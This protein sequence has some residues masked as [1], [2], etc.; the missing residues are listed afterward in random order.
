[1]RRDGMKV[2]A[3]LRALML[4]AAAAVVMTSAAWAAVH[5]RIDGARLEAMMSD[6]KPIVIVDVRE[7][8]LYKRGHVP[9]AINIPYDGARERVLT[10]LRPT[11]RIVFV[12]H[13][14]PMGDELGALL[15]EKGY[16]EVYNLIGGMR[17]WSGPLEK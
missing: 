2:L 9:G 11:D 8:W 7:P 6:G 16:G 4:T 12:C 15:K 13:G 10:E 3:G 1:M 5:V 17:R 14:G